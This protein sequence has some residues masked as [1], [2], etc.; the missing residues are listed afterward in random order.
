[1]VA[2]TGQ[3][4]AFT[5]DDPLNAT[6]PLGL[7]CGLFSFACSAYDHAAGAVKHGAKTVGRAVKSAAIWAYK[8]PQLVALALAVAAIP[9][10]G[11][12]SIALTVAS[13]G[14]NATAAV[15]DGIHHKWTSVALDVVGAVGGGAQAFSDVSEAV[16]AAQSANAYNSPAS[17]LLDQDAAFQSARSARLQGGGLG[18]SIFG[19]GASALF[20]GRL[21]GDQ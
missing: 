10:T 11:G 3:P 14:A 5:G 18:L 4:Y 19:S 17:T 16:D 20:G 15:Q 13:V 6:D 7:D 2:E 8:H 1:M 21:P 12:L 9:A